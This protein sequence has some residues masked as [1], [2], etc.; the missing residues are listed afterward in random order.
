MNNT[1]KSLS[2]AIPLILGFSSGTAKAEWVELGNI[3]S[4]YSFYRSFNLD[5]SDYVSEE[6]I[7]SN[8]VTF[9]LLNTQ[10]VTF[11][12]N[13]FTFPSLSTEF[14]QIDLLDQGLQ[15]G[16]LHGVNY[17]DGIG[18]YYDG[19]NGQEARFFKT[20]GPGD[21]QVNYKV[22]G[23][24]LGYSDSRVVGKAA[25]GLGNYRLGLSIGGLISPNLPDGPAVS[26]V[27]EPETYAMLLAGLILIGFTARR[28][29]NTE[30]LN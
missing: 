9:T 25:Q 18:D 1:L 2:L 20:L 12:A 28:R 30:R 14:R 5:T 23:Q 27:P 11:Y 15:N 16:N 10:T 24:E 17:I 7:A 26:P 13:S 6:N 22:L 21:Y 4:G 19:L 29:D 3:D 8:S